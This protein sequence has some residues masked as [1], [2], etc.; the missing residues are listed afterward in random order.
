VVT[1]IDAAVALLLHNNEPVVFDA[2]SVD[3]P[4]LSATF[5][6]GAEGIAFTVTAAE[7]VTPHAF[8]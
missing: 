8:V 7:A 3:E 6:V 4:Q 1:L 2:S 5:T